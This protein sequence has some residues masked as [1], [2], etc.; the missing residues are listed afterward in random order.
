MGFIDDDE[1]EYMIN[2]ANIMTEVIIIE[3][4]H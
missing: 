4:M 2:L 1:A 3:A